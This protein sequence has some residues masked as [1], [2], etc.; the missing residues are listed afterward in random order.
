[1]QKTPNL[2]PKKDRNWWKPH[3]LLA[4]LQYRIRG[5]LSRP[6]RRTPKSLR[7]G[8]ASE[9]DDFRHMSFTF[10]VIALSARIAC[11]DGELSRDKYIAFRESFPLR[12]TICSKI[13]ALFTLACDNPTPF[14]QYVTQIRLAFPKQPELYLTLTDR[15]FRIAVAGD[16]LTRTAEHMLAD[17]ARQLDISPADYATIRARYEQPD[18]RTIHAAQHVLGVNARTSEG[19]IKKRYRDLMRRYHPDRYAGQDLSPEVREL[20]S[21]KSSEISAAYRALTKRAA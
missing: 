13:R 8:M 5:W 4:V 17:I 14:E 18:R 2:A 15:L 7:R 12:G 10:A 21:I 19:A 6:G 1:L 16:T 11:I 20:L 3:W 9:G